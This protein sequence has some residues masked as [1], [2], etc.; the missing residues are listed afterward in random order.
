MM[1]WCRKIAVCLTLPLFFILPSVVA[2]EQIDSFAA[3]YEV[4]QDGSVTVTE[5]IEYDFGTANKRG[6][7]RILEKSHPQN[8]TSWF[9]KRSVNIDVH[10]VLRNVRD[11][12]PEPYVITEQGDQIEIRIGNP[13]VYITGVQTY[14]IVYTLYGALSYGTAG[15]EFYWNS[16]GHNWPVDIVSASAQILA[17]TELLIVNEQQCY[18]GLVGGREACVVA[19]TAVDETTTSVLFTAN[20]LSSGE[21]LTIAQAVNPALVKEMVVEEWSLWW[22]WLLLGL[23]L[24]LGIAITVYRLQTRHQ[25][26]VPIITQFEPYQGFLPMYTGVLFDRSLDPHDIT[27]GIVYLAE[28]GF[29]KI[30]RVETSVL[31]IFN[32]SDYKLTLLRSLED[33]PNVALRVLLEWIFAPIPKKQSITISIITNAL[34]GNTQPQPIEVMNTITLSTLASQ[35]LTNRQANLK[36][37]KIFKDKLTIEGYLEKPN[38]FIGIHKGVF[39]MSFW[40]VIL[41]LIAVSLI[42]KTIVPIFIVSFIFIFLVARAVPR[43]TK[44][45]FEARFHLLG[46]KQFLS[47][48]DTERFAFHNAPEK[49]PEVFMKYL[50]Y[51]IALKVEKEWA[52]AFEGITIPKPEW[53]D[54]ASVSAF[55][56]AAFTSDMSAFST[57]FSTSSGT[58]GSSGGGSSGGGGGGGGGGSW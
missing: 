43:R 20:S 25:P 56:A 3:T 7:F 38:S 19:V 55:S 32:K 17:P 1:T 44:K 58:S 8:A 21:G 39:A 45:G 5:T 4:N 37:Q 35:H 13:D 36:L 27:A 41:S 42:F 23:L 47:V 40:T 18:V 52:K 2:A 29:I 26:N 34:S 14:T 9:K 11:V 51:A 33:A 54:G 24:T 49:N 6:I 15:A 30:R 48:T 31:G 50:P 16:T 53:Y 12:I 57:S 22:M 46:F 28:Q 10:K